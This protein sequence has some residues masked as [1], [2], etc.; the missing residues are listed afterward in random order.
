MKMKTKIKTH[1]H[2]FYRKF[3]SRWTRLS[4]PVRVLILL[5]GIAATAFFTYIFRGSTAF[6]DEQRYRLAERANLVGPAQILDI[7][8]ISV[9]QGY[10]Y[11]R[12]VIADDGDS[13]ILYFWNTKLKRYDTLLY[14]K[15]VGD[16]TVYPAQI[17]RFLYDL[18]GSKEIILPVY[19]FDSYPEA[20]R[21]ELKLTLNF[22][23][24]S[25]EYI[26]EYSLQ[27]EREKAGFFSFYIHVANP[28]EA[29]AMALDQFSFLT[30]SRYFDRDSKAVADIR[31]Y[32]T[33]NTMLYEETHTILPAFIETMIEHGIHLR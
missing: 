20:V 3:L 18:R 25:K 23:L 4:R 22:S 5:T 19:A 14:R 32:D 29:E 13:I 33:N 27:A 26:F 21:A 30:G 28:S 11:N 8:D 31:L 17:S 9:Q 7:Q 15:K 24:N 16:V 10:H 1:I 2:R 6:T 12:V